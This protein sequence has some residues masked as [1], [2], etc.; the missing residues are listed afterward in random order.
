MRRVPE[1]R[2]KENKNKETRTATRAMRRVPEAI[3]SVRRPRLNLVLKNKEDREKKK[4]GF[5]C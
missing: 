1:E 4:Q 5:P 2:K 3:H